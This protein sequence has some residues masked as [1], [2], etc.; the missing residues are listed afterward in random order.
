MTQT[1][2]AEWA[3][4]QYG[5]AKP[6]SQTTI[7]RILKSKSEIIGSKDSDLRRLRRRKRNNPLLRKILTE[8]ITQALWEGIPYTTPIIQLTAHAIWTRLPLKAKDG[9][10]IFTSKWCNTFVRGLDIN[11]IGSDAAIDDNMGIP[12]NKV[13][14]LDEKLQLK[15]YIK[16]M[17]QRKHY[18]PADLFTIDEIQLFHGLPLDQIFDVSSIDKGLKQAGSS[19]ESMLTLMLGCNMDGSEKLTPIVVSRKGH[20]DLPSVTN[21]ALS[22]EDI[23]NRI[24]SM[25]NILHY[26]NN[27]KWITSSMF[28]DYLLSLEHKLEVSGRNIMI[29][30]DN[31]STHRVINLQLKRIRLCYLD[32]ASKHKNPYGGSF[33]GTR[34]DY[35]PMSYGIATEFKTLYRIQHYSEMVA[36]QR[37]IKT[38]GEFSKSGGTLSESDYR[39]PFTQVLDWIKNAWEALLKEVIFLSWKQTYLVSF[40][41]PW[42]CDDP[43]VQ[44]RGEAAIRPL[45]LSLNNKP[46]VSS[47]NRLVEVIPRLDVVMPWDANDLLGLVNERSK[48]S[49]N[50][51]SIVEI[52]GSCCR[53]PGSEG[54]DD[55]ESHDDNLSFQAT[56][57]DDR[58]MRA[59]A[60]IDPAIR[61]ERF[62]FP[63]EGDNQAGWNTVYAKGRD[64]ELMSLKR[65]FD[66]DFANQKMRPS[67]LNN[68]LTPESIAHLES[69]GLL[70]H[71][72]SPIE[73]FEP[74]EKKSRPELADVLNRVIEASRSNE[75]QLSHSVLRELELNL[76]VIE[77]GY[78]K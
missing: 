52:V 25:Y 12:L 61:Q 54:D 59:N 44:R 40:K 51:L 50:Y 67:I 5:C 75:L 33:S 31:S 22:P 65:P 15:Q 42:P 2:L 45:L 16:N 71:P 39:V 66:N 34:F 11:L 41:E 48:V 20:I 77:S 14:M 76:S 55:H 35:L 9:N 63:L 4:A 18:L 64:F 21:R 60:F 27:N 70:S 24:N 72:L 10:G 3:M 43:L 47:F 26:T 57:F 28:Q 74:L 30:L 13:W 58:D 46:D 7:C 49:L 56:W 1:D 37:G 29:F 53:E 17:I 78:E 8:W 69:N 68:E 36:R 23:H 32:N 73:H 38:G 62:E 6:P 19:L